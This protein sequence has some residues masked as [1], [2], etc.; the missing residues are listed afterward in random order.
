MTALPPCREVLE[1]LGD[2]DAGELD[3]VRT[4]AFERHLELCASCRNYLHSYRVTIQL[5]KDA[6]AEPELR[7]PPEE[8]VA[9]ILSIRRPG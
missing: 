9:T 5:E 1:F 6:F 7:E 4:A 8:L 3:P 2:Y